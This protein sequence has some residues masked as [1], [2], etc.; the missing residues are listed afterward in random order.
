M[1]LLREFLVLLNSKNPS[2]LDLIKTKFE[3]LVLSGPPENDRVDPGSKA[4]SKNVGAL[5]G[6]VSSGP[7]QTSNTVY[8]KEHDELVKKVLLEFDSTTTG[9]DF[10]AFPHY[11]HHRPFSV[12]LPILASDLT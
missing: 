7:H 10:D 11:D 1:E 9:S 3:R 8:N 4:T 6:E 12:I 2:T 5:S